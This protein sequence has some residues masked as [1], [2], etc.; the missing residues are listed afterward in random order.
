MRA[1]SSERQPRSC[2]P[3]PRAARS[4][5]AVMYSTS[6]TGSSRTPAACAR[7]RSWPARRVLG[8]PARVVEDQRRL[9][10]PLDRHRLAHPLGIGGDVEQLLAPDRPDLEPAVA[11]PAGSRARPRAARRARR[12]PPRPSSGRSR[13]PARPGTGRGTP[14]P[15]PPSSEWCAPPK[16]PNATVPPTSVAH[17]A[18]GLQRLLRLGQHPLRV[19]PEQPP[20]VGQLDAR[21]RRGR[22]AA[23]RA[24]P[25]AGGSAPTGSAAPSAARAAAAEND[26]V[27]GRR[28]EV[29]ELL[30]R[31]RLSLSTSSQSSLKQCGTSVDT[32][33]MIAIALIA[34]V[35]VG[36]VFRRRGSSRLRRVLLRWP[37]VRGAHGAAPQATAAPPARPPGQAA[38]GRRGLGV[39]AQMGRIPRHRL[40]RWR[41]TSISSHAAASRCAG[42]S[43]S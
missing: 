42:T 17:L 12:R 18:H 27:L 39:R 20:G 9:G 24:R 29:F 36:T 28:E 37:K 7:S 3:S 5:A 30:Q 22:T 1:R 13:A 10:E 15:A 2:R 16:K 25:R 32:R 8:R 43:P 21:A 11:R 41:R 33:C 19:R 4:N 14:A 6:I 40:R 26:P 34:A 31:H 38:P 23:R 35:A